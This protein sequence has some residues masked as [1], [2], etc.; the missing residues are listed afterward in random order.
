MSVPTAPDEQTLDPDDAQADSGVDRR[1]FLTYLVAA[2]T[3]TVA[4]RLATDTGSAA[5]QTPGLPGILDLGDALI[6]A[7]TPTAYSLR[8]EVTAAGRAVLHLPRAEVG[9]GITTATAMIVAE[10]LDARLS[11]VDVLLADADPALLFNQLTGGSNSVRSL[12]TPLRTVARAARARLVTAAAQ[13]WGL[14]AGQ[15]TTRDSAVR[16]PD[17]RTLGYGALSAD[18]ARVLIPAVP[19][20]PKPAAQYTV[21]GRPTT[22]IDARAIVTGQVQYAGDLR[23]PGALSTVV[24]RPPT[25]DGTVR[26]VDDSAARAA[27]PGVLISRI[28]SGVAVSATNFHDAMR[29]RD[30]LRITWNAGPASAMSDAQIRGRLAAAQLPLVVPPLLSSHLDAT[31]EFNYVNHAPLEV[32]TAVADVRADRAE[33]W[34]PAKSPIIAAQTIAAAIGLPV[35]A[36][37]VHVI[38]GGGSFGRRLFFDHGLEAALISKAIGRPVKL[39]WTRNDDM[40][41]GRCRP[42]SHHRLRATWLAGLFLSFEHRVACAETDLRHGLGEALTAAGAMVSPLGLS[43]SVFMLTQEVPYNFGVV[44]ELLSEVP[45]PV[46][47]ASW[48]SVYSGFTAMA[49][50]IMVDELARRFGQD[51]LAFRRARLSDA[52]LRAVLDRVAA[53]GQWGRAMPAGTAQGIAVH[54]EYKSAVAH[55]VEVDTRPSPDR[56]DGQ[57]RVTRVCI[58]ADVGTC[59]NPRGLEAQLIGAFTDAQST[60]FAA[61]NHLDNGAIREGSFTDFK[62][63]RMKH[64]PTSYEVHI[65]PSTAPPGG[66]GELGIPGAGAACANAY[67]RATGTSPRRFPIFGF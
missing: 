51:P 46:P 31:F 35:S 14:P 1:R 6:L 53:M 54:K 52:R 24:A 10:E 33:L 62:Y 39:L 60:T 45:L 29:A 4:A 59:V 18:A 44:T 13:R 26:T 27:V 64:T 25:V 58:A 2:P 3:L 21:V 41:H 50:E 42:A 49:D 34:F 43:Q 48:R 55:L 30:L 22:R 8:L 19:S 12:W 17:G 67:A 9:Q 63:A 65:M 66:A 28:P 7:G 56:P 15:L 11:D 20:T 61:G 32:G 36:V 47:T 57:P 37:T 40:R 23:V 16:A 5:A 38:R